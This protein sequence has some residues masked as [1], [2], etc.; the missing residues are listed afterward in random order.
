MA[1]VRLAEGSFACCIY[2]TWHD[3]IAAGVW[4]ISLASGS[5]EAQLSDG[6]PAAV[7]AGTATGTAVSIDRTTGELSFIGGSPAKV[8][9]SVNVGLEPSAVAVDSATG[10]STSRIRRWQAP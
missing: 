7:A 2:V 8:R 5:T 4:A 3:G 10:A 9:G 1:F 6:C